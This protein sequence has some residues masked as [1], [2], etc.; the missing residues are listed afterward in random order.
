[1][2]TFRELLFCQERGGDTYEIAW[3][4]AIRSKKDH[5]CMNQTAPKLVNFEGWLEDRQWCELETYDVTQQKELVCY[6]LPGETVDEWN[7]YARYL[8]Y[9]FRHISCRCCDR[10]KP[11]S[12]PWEEWLQELMRLN[13]RPCPKAAM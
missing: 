2:G 9:Y 1:M 12:H 6:I 5:I 13:L 3:V 4:A 8:P 7:T 10:S 11:A